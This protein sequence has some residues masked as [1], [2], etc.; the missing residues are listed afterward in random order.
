MRLKR[1]T[2]VWIFV[3]L[4]V[5]GVVVGLTLHRIGQRRVSRPDIRNVLLI[6]IDTCRRDRLYCYG[7][8]RP[9]TPNIDAL[10]EQ[11]VIFTEAVTPVPLTL[12]AHSSMLTGT[13][14]RCT[15][16][17]GLSARRPQ[18]DA[19][20][21]LERTWPVHRCRDRRLRPGITVR[22]GSGV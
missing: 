1:T 11:G 9:T 12:P 10:A 21:N 16:Q 18:R 17:R 6:S 3:G 5:L 15:R 20:R 8:E 14:S 7:F 19:R 4:G 22:F 13:N 2:L